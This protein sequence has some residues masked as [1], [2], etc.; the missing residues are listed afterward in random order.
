MFGNII[1]NQE[2]QCPSVSSLTILFLAKRAAPFKFRGVGEQ[3]FPLCLPPCL[4]PRTCVDICSHHQPPST[5]GCP[6]SL[7]GCAGPPGFRGGVLRVCMKPKGL[8]LSVRM[9]AS[10]RNQASLSLPCAT[11]WTLTSIALHFIIC[12]LLK[13]RQARGPE[14][15]L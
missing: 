13:I 1:V 15:L 12:Q 2:K 4:Q 3:P 10:R 14:S 8:G 7:L 5:L 6:R 11:S 9:L